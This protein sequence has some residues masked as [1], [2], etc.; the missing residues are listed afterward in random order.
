MEQLGLEGTLQPIQFQPPAVG[1]VLTTSSGCSGLTHSLGHL[2]GWGTRNFFGQQCPLGHPLLL[3]CSCWAFMMAISF[4]TSQMW[5]V[6]LATS[7]RSRSR[8][9]SSCSM[10]CCFSFRAS[11]RAVVPEILRA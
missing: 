7:A 4:S 11:W 10:C 2:Q 6:A 9:A 3:T 1:W 8:S 5:L